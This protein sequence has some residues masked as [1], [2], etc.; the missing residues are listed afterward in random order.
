MHM[1]FGTVV[2]AQE[3]PMLKVISSVIWEGGENQYTIMLTNEVLN[4]SGVR[5]P[6]SIIQ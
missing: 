4:V 3:V 2:E 6:V 1:D 5:V